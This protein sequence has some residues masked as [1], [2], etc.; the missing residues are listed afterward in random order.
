MTQSTTL[1]EKNVDG[2]GQGYSVLTEFSLL[3]THI[4]DF[5]FIPIS[6]KPTAYFLKWKPVSL[7]AITLYKLEHFQNLLTGK[8][9]HDLKIFFLM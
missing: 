6:Y 8:Q 2:G 4:I 9:F 7:V 3:Q 5:V 1:K